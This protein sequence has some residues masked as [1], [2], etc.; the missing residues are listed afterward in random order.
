MR[1]GTSS[2]Y[3]PEPTTI[4]DRGG[5]PHVTVT[6]PA[7]GGLALVATDVA[8]AEARRRAIAYQHAVRARSRTL[9]EDLAEHLG[10]LQ[11]P[12]EPHRVPEVLEDVRDKIAALAAYVGRFAPPPDHPGPLTT[13]AALVDAIDAEIRLADLGDHPAQQ[14]ATAAAAALL[15]GAS[16]LVH[17]GDTG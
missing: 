11:D 9:C 17:G 7:P 14:R 10:W 6:A 15:A 1:T 2:G 16:A 8:M 4:T 3:D 5:H 12:D 13:L